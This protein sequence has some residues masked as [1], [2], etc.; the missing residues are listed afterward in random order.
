MEFWSLVS[1]ISLP[2]VAGFILGVILGYASIKLLKQALKYAALIVLALILGALLHLWRVEIEKEQDLL[3]SLAS[4]LM[5]LASIAF[6]LAESVELTVTGPLVI[7]VVAGAL[8]ALL[9]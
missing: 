4:A 8:I 6:S 5:Q 2:I 9:R 3:A 7:G 1:E